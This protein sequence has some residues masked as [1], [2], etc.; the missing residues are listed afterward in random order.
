MGTHTDPILA[1]DQLETPVVADVTTD[2]AAETAEP[3]DAPEA[4]AEG[5]GEAGPKKLISLRVANDDLELAKTLAADLGIGY[6]T[7]LNQLIHDGLVSKREDVK[8]E[9]LV[10]QLRGTLP[11]LKLAQD[12]LDAP[13]VKAARELLSN[14]AVKAA[15]ALV[16][17]PAAKAAQNFADEVAKNPTVKQVKDFGITSYAKAAEDFSASP[18]AKALKDLAENPTVKAAQELA[19]NTGAKVVRDVSNS[20]IGRL[21]RELA[22]AAGMPVPAQG[23][24]LKEL[25]KAVDEIRDALKK[26][27]LL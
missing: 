8:Y 12:I 23:D 24:E 13:A 2:A 21:S 3:A 18:L 9:R 11:E 22:T 26:A 15:E 27:N 10:A 5:K 16:D 14:P 17:S 6:Q 20:P 4:D 19:E 1:D 25:T 7:L